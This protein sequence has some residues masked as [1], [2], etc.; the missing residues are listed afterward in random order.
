MQSPPRTPRP[1]RRERREEAVDGY[2]GREIL[3]EV[4]AEEEQQCARLAA[5]L[6]RRQE[7]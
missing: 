4:M 6:G 7:G 5:S 3:A 1:C 2:L